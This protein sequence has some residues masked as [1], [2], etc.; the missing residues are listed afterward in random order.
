M[1]GR[2]IDS[3]SSKIRLYL[4][5]PNLGGVESEVIEMQDDCASVFYYIQKLA[6]LATWNSGSA[7]EYKSEKNRR[8]WEPVYTVIYEALCVGDDN[9]PVPPPSCVAKLLGKT[10]SK[11]NANDEFAGLINEVCE[12]MLFGKLWSDS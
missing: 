10:A 6:S 7:G 1:G 12:Q 4:K 3:G 2:S 5:G 8:I 11:E 9:E